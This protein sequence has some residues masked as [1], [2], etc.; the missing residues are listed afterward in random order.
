MTN[1]RIKYKT[2]DP[3]IIQLA[4]VY[5]QDPQAILEVKLA[6]PIKPG[7]SASFDMIY[8]AQ[9]PVMKKLP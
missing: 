5:H 2:I 9:V 6:K 8:D 3:Q 1:K 7:H 4:K